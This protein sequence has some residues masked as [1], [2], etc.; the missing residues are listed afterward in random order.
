MLFTIKE[1]REKDTYQRAVEDRGL[2][3]RSPVYIS[4]AI[5]IATYRHNHHKRT[6]VSGA[7]KHARVMVML[8]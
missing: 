1:K 2:I 6:P 5:T 4:S 8:T 3:D 7:P